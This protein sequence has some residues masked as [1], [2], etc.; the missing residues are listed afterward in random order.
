MIVQRGVATQWL[1][2]AKEGETLVYARVTFLPVAS[3]VARMMREA[4]AAG[5]VTLS[6]R[7]RDHGPGGENF[8]YI[9]R[10]TGKAHV[11][12][13]PV[14]SGPATLTHKPQDKRLSSCAAVAIDIAPQVR[15]MLAEGGRHNAM[16]IARALGVYSVDPVRVALRNIERMAA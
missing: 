13:E 11:S 12:L 7:R 1:R 10:R 5:L 8:H 15:S 2:E 14:P 3:E 9:A 4:Q 16:S 6:Q